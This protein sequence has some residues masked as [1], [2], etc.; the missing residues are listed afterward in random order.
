MQHK[1]VTCHMHNPNAQH[2]R[3]RDI[4][5]IKQLMNGLKKKR[6]LKLAKRSLKKNITDS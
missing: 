6:D 5:K 4:M 1:V 3:R 2:M